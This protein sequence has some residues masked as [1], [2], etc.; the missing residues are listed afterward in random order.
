MNGSPIVEGELLLLRR[1]GGGESLLVRASAGPRS[2]QGLGVLD[3]GPVIGK[4]AG[5]EL[6][7]AGAS[8]QALRPSVGDLLGQ[9]RRKA[10]IITPKD[11]SYLAFLAGIGPGSRVAEA[12]AGSGA[13]T[14]VLAHC[15]GP[16]GHVVSCDR[17][18]DFLSVARG[19]LESTGLLDR[20]EFIERDVVALGFPGE[21]FDAVVLDLPEPW[22]AIPGASV[23]L[24][25]GGFLATYTPTYNQLERTVRALRERGYSE[26]RSVELLERAL[27][28]GDGG[29]RPEFEMLGHTGFLTVGRK[30]E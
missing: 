25:I 18:A 9:L 24:K 16:Q 2:I 30:E 4:P 19:N 5:Y 12:G 15:V 27:H 20:V 21:G 17:R 7:W 26:V 6:R 10:Q 11:A 28:V 23:A 29:T 22:A 14:L 1:R 13:L 3:L 8:Y